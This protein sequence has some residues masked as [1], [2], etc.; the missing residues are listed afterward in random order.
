MYVITHESIL[1]LCVI[2]HKGQVEKMS[3]RLKK[4]IAQRLKAIRKQRGLS[5]DV[6]AKL[7]GVSKAML[8]QIEREESS[9]T[10]SKLWQIA[11]GLDVSFSSFFTVNPLLPK[12]HRTFIDESGMKIR[13]VFPFQQDTNIEVFDVSLTNYH[14]QISVPH[15]IGVIEHVIVMSGELDLFFDG[16]WY[17]LKE[18]DTVRF[19]ADQKHIYKAKSASAR[20]QNII[21]YPKR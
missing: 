5:L 21:S 16:N 2:T 7:T 18:G 19:H 20:F 12:E 3:D 10:I 1:I 17:L 4:Q 15:S 8:G 14:E 13:T 11:T 6:T 9:P